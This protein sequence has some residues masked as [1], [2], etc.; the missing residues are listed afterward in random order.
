MTITA[1]VLIRSKSGKRIGGDT[2][3]TSKN[4]AEYQPSSA[5]VEE[6]QAA[7]QAAG[8]ETGNLVGISFSITAAIDEFESF[9]STRLERQQS[10]AIAVHE[11]GS[12]PRS[13]LPLD[14]LAPRI[15]ERVVAVTFD[16]PAELFG[17]G[18]FGS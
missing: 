6:V 15:A 3:I 12:E 13:E 5:D 11:P 4:I 2:E 9:F 10:G 18:Q 14:H 8:F 16:P 7:F 1:Q 17:A